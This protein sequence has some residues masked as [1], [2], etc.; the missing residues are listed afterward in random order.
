LTA[1]STRTSASANLPHLLIGR[2]D[3]GA[4]PGPNVHQ[5]S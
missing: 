5:V 4:G 1:S 3:A 2:V